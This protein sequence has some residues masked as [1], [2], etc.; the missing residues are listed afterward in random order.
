MLIAGRESDALLK[1][2]V[3]G[4][5]EFEKGQLVLNYF[6][7]PKKQPNKFRLILC[8]LKGLNE[9]AK[10]NHFKMETVH[11]ATR[12]MRRGCHMTTIDLS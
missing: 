7:R 12:M 6:L 8:N 10:Y 2:G 5:S 11:S 3:I 4:P 9:I 1:E